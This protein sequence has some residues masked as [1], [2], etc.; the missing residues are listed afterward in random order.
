MKRLLVKPVVILPVLFAAAVLVRIPN[1]NRPLSKHHEFC[2]ALSLIVMQSWY[3]GGIASYHF[4]PSTNF[5]GEQ[6][7]GIR[8]LV[9]ESVAS[10][11]HYYYISHPPLAYYLPFALFKITGQRPD[12]LGLQWFNIVAHVVSA[13]FIFL[14]ARLLFPDS[15]FR[16]WRDSPSAV[17]WGAAG[18]VALFY[19]FNPATL[20]FQGN[21]YMADMFVQVFFIMALYFYA[22]ITMRDAGAS[23][24]G[25]TEIGASARRPYESVALA[26][27]LG[28]AV[29]TE[30][31]GLILA[32]VLLV[33]TFFRRPIRWGLLVTIGLAAAL[34][35]VLTILTYANIAGWEAMKEYYFGRFEERGPGGDVLQTIL[36]LGKN[37]LFNHLPLLLLIAVALVALL[38]RM[39]KSERSGLPAFAKE[40]I[41]I[42]V[43]AVVLHHLIFLQYSGH[44]FAVLKSAVPLALLGAWLIHH[45]TTRG[46][47]SRRLAWAAVAGVSALSIGQ[48]YY[49]NRPGEVSWKGDRYDE[50][51]LIGRAIAA[52]SAAD[53]VAFVKDIEL[54][55]Q[56]LYYAQRNVMPVNHRAEAYNFVRAHPLGKGVL[57]WNEDGAWKVLRIIRTGE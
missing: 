56:I 49:I 52:N 22:R 14:L 50:E 28:A 46:V 43:V 16:L 37:Y 35:L 21:V 55:P 4:A 54:T 39:R 18:C 41:F 7:R 36:L 57:I 26:L 8:N 17:G 48:Y 51:M 33:W 24:T 27:S 10:D 6:N 29:Y 40:I 44:D 25:A 20:W 15:P 47:P 9:A 30:W 32:G 34:P 5:P 19:L 13:L 53:E 23:A 1:L 38:R 45:V 11:G 42:S 31:L 3:D 12:V 2:M